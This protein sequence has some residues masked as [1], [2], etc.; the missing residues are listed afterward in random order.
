MSCRF[1]LI[2]FV[3]LMLTAVSAFAEKKPKIPTSSKGGNSTVVDQGNFNVLVNGQRVATETFTITQLDSG[4]VTTSELRAESDKIAQKSELFLN[5][6]G[7]LQKYQWQQVS[8]SKEQYLVFPK[9]DFL[10]EHMVAA[11]GKVSEQP[12]LLPVST[13]ILD[14][15]FFS[16]RELLLWRYLGE[17]CHM[18]PGKDGCSL[19]KVSYGSLIPRQRISAVTSVEYK[20]REVLQI[21]GDAVL[22]D[23]FVIE[24][25]GP[26]WDLWM[27]GDHKLQRVVIAESSTEVVRN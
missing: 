13:I 11:D 10:N 16:Q 24:S 19:S 2:A 9:D 8:P 3:L 17:N 27:D 20:G 5:A 23:H 25:E 15:Y 21:K 22:L 4:S 12:F 26:K 18:E 7:G 14:D 6:V 1:R